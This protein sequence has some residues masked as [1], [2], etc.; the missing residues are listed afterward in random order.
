MRIAFL[1]VFC[2]PLMAF[3][4]GAPPE[5]PATIGVEEV[6]PVEDL[7]RE[8]GVLDRI[9]LIYE[10]IIQQMDRNQAVSPQLQR[11]AGLVRKFIEDYHEKLEENYVFK[12]CMQAKIQVDLVQTLLEQ[13]QR[14]RSLTDELLA[15]SSD[16]Q[17]PDIQKKVRA[18]MCS[19]ITMYRPHAARE[20]TVLFPAFKTL[21]TTDEYNHLGEV[22]EDQETKLF[23]DNGF[24]SVVAEV[25]GLE[26]ELG[27]NN[28]AQFTPQSSR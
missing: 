23:G 12:K 9:L 1:C 15:N 18:A 10:K 27:I 4:A 3:G 2:F 22:F 5:P 8:H 14:G 7:M 19:F 6:S 26:K 20:D 16:L 24:K 21:V 28:L 13:H 17:N 25:E 11:S